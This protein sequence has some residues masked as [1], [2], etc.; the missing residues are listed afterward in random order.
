MD[1]YHSLKDPC[2]GR[3]SWSGPKDAG[4]LN[5]VRR[6]TCWRGCLCYIMFLIVEYR[7]DK[8]KRRQDRDYLLTS[9]GRTASP[10]ERRKREGRRKEREEDVAFLKIGR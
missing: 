8:R 10:G 2:P 7:A 4:Y 9:Q 3:I 5:G 1:A 6:T